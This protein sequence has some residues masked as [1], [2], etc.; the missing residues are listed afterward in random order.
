M[1]HGSD[2]LCA[3]LLKRCILLFD[4]CRNVPR[5]DEHI[6]GLTY[7]YGFRGQDGYVAAR[8]VFAL[9]GNGS[10]THK[11]QQV[12]LNA[13]V[14]EQGVA[15]GGGTVGDHRFAGTLLLDQK[16]EQVVFHFIGT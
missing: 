9:L 12:R 5:Q 13:S 8:H 3:L 4:L 6:V 7:L 15:F 2:E 10:I 1:G 14:V 11:G 16:G